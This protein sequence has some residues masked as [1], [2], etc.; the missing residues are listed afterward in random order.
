MF[1]TGAQTPLLALLSLRRAP[2]LFVVAFPYVAL[3]LLL[4]PLSG[5]TGLALLVLGPAP[6]IGGRIAP[7]VG[8]RQDRVGALGVATL[9]IAFVLLLGG[10]P[11]VA[12]VLQPVIIAF[13]AGLVLAG[14]VPTLRDRLLPLLDGARYVAIGVILVILAVVAAPTLDGRSVGIAA[15]VLLVGV[16]AAAAIAAVMGTDPVSAALGAGIRDPVVAGGLILATG[17]GD[18]LA[19]PLAYAGLLAV[20]LLALGLGRKLFVRRDA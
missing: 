1:A 7:L 15:G 12:G 14:T 13:V 3:G 6:L 9:V 10:T 2:N 8:A 17:G 11:A 5:F 16:I 4:L 18:A 19:I 20:A